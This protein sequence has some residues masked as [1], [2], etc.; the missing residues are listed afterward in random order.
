MHNLR[1]FYYENKE[2]IWKVVSIIAFVLVIIYFAN[3]NRQ[4]TV[5]NN[6]EKELNQQESLYVDKE[7]NTYISDK[8]LISGESVGKKET[9]KIKD[10]ISKFL[11]YCKEE[12]FK[13]AYQMVSKDCRYKKYPTIEDFTTKY[14]K[15]KFPKNHTYEIE[16]WIANTYRI[17]ISEDILAT[18]NINNN[19]K[20]IEYITIIEENSENKLNIGNYVGQQTLKKEAIEKNVKI[21]AQNKEIYMDY[22]IYNFKIE[23]NSDKIIKLDSLERTNTI[24]LEDSDGYKYSAY[25]NEIL[26]DEL[27][28]LSKA[29]QEISIKFS[30]SIS[31][32]KRIKKIIFSNFIFDYNENEIEQK[33]TTEIVINCN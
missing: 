3:Q 1:R 22:E 31:S 20:H 2:K 28:V 13:E 6:D 30:N 23:N 29:E 15:T 11:K 32:N 16:P 33:N 21:I 10:T 8:T 19:S 4:K 12:N 17:S 18:G 26:E 14:V 5:S 27:V 7:N 25:S 24:F 9:E